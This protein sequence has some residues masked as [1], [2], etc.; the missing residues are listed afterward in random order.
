MEHAARRV[1]QPP[2]VSRPASPAEERAVPAGVVSPAASAPAL[3]LP[4]LPQVDVSLPQ[5]QL[6]G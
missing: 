2:S 6:P 4:Q 1:Q 3:V 5:L